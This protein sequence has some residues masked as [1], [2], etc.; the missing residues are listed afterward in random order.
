MKRMKGNVFHLLQII[1]HGKKTW[2]LSRLQKK[3]TSGYGNLL[4]LTVQKKVCMQ[5]IYATVASTREINRP[6]SYSTTCW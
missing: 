4:K 3:V 5:N 6:E 1:K 2:A